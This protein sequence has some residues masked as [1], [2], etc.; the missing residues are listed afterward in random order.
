MRVVVL[1]SIAV[2]LLPAATQELGAQLHQL[3]QQTLPECEL[4]FADDRFVIAYRTRD[5]QI[6]SPDK[7]GAWQPYRTKTGPDR[8]GILIEGT[9]SD[10][11]WRGAMAIGE[12]DIDTTDF[13]VYT[14]RTLIEP[15][16]DQQSYLWLRILIP[17]LDGDNDLAAAIERR[18]RDSFAS[19]HSPPRDLFWEGEI[20]QAL[21]AVKEMFQRTEVAAN[22]PD[23][24]AQRSTAFALHWYAQ[25]YH[26]LLAHRQDPRKKLH[27][28]EKEIEK[29]RQ[30]LIDSAALKTT[31]GVKE[32]TQRLE[33]LETARKRYR[34]MVD[35][36]TD[37]QTDETIE[38]KIGYDNESDS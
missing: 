20:N 31:D 14:Q 38:K 15:A 13:Y 35:S 12:H 29:V 7:T 27:H 9:I 26:D 21:A 5:F 32:H 37:E 24:R 25:Q 18:A 22:E 19:L 6:T 34:R 36:D 3:V 28:V 11:A 4:S 33:Q 2:V 10:Q 30:F 8:G 23:Q 16:P 17:R 1:L